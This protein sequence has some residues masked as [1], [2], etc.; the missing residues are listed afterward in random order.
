MSPS[1]YAFVNMSDVSLFEE[2]TFIHS[3][4]MSFKCIFDN[5]GF[6]VIKILKNVQCKINL[7]FYKHGKI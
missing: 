1:T 3:Y 6:G 7:N 5:K 2:Q 4:L